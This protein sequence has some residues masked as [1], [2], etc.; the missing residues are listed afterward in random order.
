MTFEE[1]RRICRVRKEEELTK[2]LKDLK[3]DYENRDSSLQLINERRKKT[4]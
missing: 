4:T 2:A 3:V 1:L